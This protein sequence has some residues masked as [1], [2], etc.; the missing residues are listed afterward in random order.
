MSAQEGTGWNVAA[1]HV[2]GLDWT[3]E[4]VSCQSNTDTPTPPLALCFA[5]ITKQC[6]RTS[7]AFLQDNSRCKVHLGQTTHSAVFFRNYQVIYDWLLPQWKL[8]VQTWQPSRLDV[9]VMSLNSFPTCAMHR[10]CRGQ[11]AT[12]AMPEVRVYA[13][14]PLCS[15]LLKG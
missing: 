9:M 5:P 1:G 2:T 14:T 15:T 11:G 8:K 3:G 10:S 6:S 7:R 4:C 13:L 12:G